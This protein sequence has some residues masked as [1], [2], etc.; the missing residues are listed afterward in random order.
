MRGEM[1]ITV[2]IP[3]FRGKRYISYWLDKLR[4]NFEILSS[5]LEQQGEIIFVNDC[6]DEIIEIDDCWTEKVNV[7]LINC[8][9]N[10]G[11]HKARV[12]GLSQATGE[13]I[14]FLDQDDKISDDYIYSQRIQ[15]TDK[16]AVL[17]NGYTEKY[18]MIVKRLIYADIFEQQKA[19][20]LKCMLEET[21][22]II[23]PGQVMI[24]RKA[25][26]LLWSRKIMQVNGA[27]DYFLWILL[28]A[29]KRTFA[30]NEERL[31]SHIETGMNT[32]GN[33]K[34]MR[35]S[36]RELYAIL[37]SS[38][39]LNKEQIK[40]L[41][42]R[43]GSLDEGHE[44]RRLTNII[45]VFDQWMYAKEQGCLFSEYLLKNNIQKVAIYGMNYLG[46]RLY[47]E[48]RNSGV[49]VIFGIDRNAVIADIPI[50]KFEDLTALEMDKAEL[51]IVTAVDAF[52]D[53]DMQISVRY[54]DTK[55]ESFLKLL[56][57]MIDSNRNSLQG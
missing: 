56:V 54:P 12:Q 4:N 20:D 22:F 6:P 2:I 42:R 17:C 36:L 32:S 44:T 29:E 25:I 51:V 55:T 30:L 18:Y 21:N 45:Q 27:D 10:V 50:Y 52:Q 34:G 7:R 11:I 41:G 37:S 48:L 43:L 23:S 14:V 49:E 26:P 24:K 15:I 9:K 46:N 5:C 33:I 8:F 19:I 16:D 13:Y 39:I 53:I 1:D 47:A 3:L 28:L 57:N 31:Y 35:D 40:K 38:H